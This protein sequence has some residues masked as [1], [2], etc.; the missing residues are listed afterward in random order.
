MASQMTEVKAE[1]TTQT[2]IIGL[3]VQDFAMS[4]TED[5]LIK[6]SIT[7]EIPQCDTLCMFHLQ[8]SRTL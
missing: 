2:P 8:C 3:H 5:I 7:K 6:I 1:S 4:M